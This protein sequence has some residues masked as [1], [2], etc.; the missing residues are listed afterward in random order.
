VLVAHLNKNEV[1][2]LIARDVESFIGPGRVVQVHCGNSF[3]PMEL[4][5]HFFRH[6]TDNLLNHHYLSGSGKEQMLRMTIKCSAPV[7]I[8]G[9]DTDDLK[10]KC[11]SSI[12]S[13]VSHPKYARQVTAGEKS[14]IYR[15][16]LELIHRYSEVEKVRE[17]K[18]D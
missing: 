7:G 18:V 5:V 11:M 16:A 14:G 9:I 2:S 1:K 17:E 6:K 12:R 10:K 13:M 3:T 4:T 15:R 8:L